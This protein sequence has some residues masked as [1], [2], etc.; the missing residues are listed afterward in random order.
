MKVRPH[1]SG[2]R[3]A[4]SFHSSYGIPPFRAR[5]RGGGRGGGGVVATGVLYG[6]FVDSP[7]RFV[8]LRD[9]R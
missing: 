9:A 7:L 3:A 5:E 6:D 4:F 8:K 2:H 1:R